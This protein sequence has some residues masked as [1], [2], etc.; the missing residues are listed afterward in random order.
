MIALVERHRVIWASQM[1]VT[2]APVICHGGTSPMAVTPASV[3]CHGGTSSMA[4]K[5]KVCLSIMAL[6]VYSA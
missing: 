2:R 6:L 5:I 1:T 3:I 4:V